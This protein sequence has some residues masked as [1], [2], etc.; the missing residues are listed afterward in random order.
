MEEKF[1]FY[2]ILA[3][4][5]TLDYSGKKDQDRLSYLLVLAGLAVSFIPSV[6]VIT[7]DP[8]LIFIIFL[9]PA[10]RIS[11]EYFMERAVEMAQDYQ[12][13]CL[14]GCILLPSQLELLLGIFIPSFT[15]ALGFLLGGIVSPPDAVSA[16][17]ILK[18]VK[19][20]KVPPLFWRAK[21]Y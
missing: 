6:P 20:P 18:N 21:A 13:F 8:E 16:G 5:I 14:F 10:L 9:P 1:I 11:M 19:Y 12:Q 17:A 4:L 3:V 15:L 2:L 7:I